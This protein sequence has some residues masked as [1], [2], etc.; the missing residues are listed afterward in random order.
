M[1]RCAECGKE[2]YLT[3]KCSVCGEDYCSEHRLPESHGCYTGKRDWSKYSNRTE[4]QKTSIEASQRSSVR[5]PR[6]STSNINV[7]IIRRPLVWYLSYGAVLGYIIF[8]P[9]NSH[10]WMTTWVQNILFA[11]SIVLGLYPVY[12]LM[13]RVDRIRL[14][15]DLKIW[16]L[17]LASLVVILGSFFFMLMGFSL[18]WAFAM[19]RGTHGEGY[20]LSYFVYAFAF[21]LLLVSGFMLFKFRRSSGVIIYSR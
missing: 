5:L 1:G 10:G 19:S 2:E 18:D 16:G 6:F 13:K 20:I 11:V 14:D 7:G 15:S 8:T 21:S 4:S 9:L 3:F 12:W 17:R